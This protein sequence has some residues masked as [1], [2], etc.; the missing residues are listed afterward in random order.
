MQWEEVSHKHMN[1]MMV[2]RMMQSLGV[3]AD[4]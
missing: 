3:L 2:R 1:L 4:S